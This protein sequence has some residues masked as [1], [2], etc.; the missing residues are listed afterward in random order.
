MEEE[1]E[2]EEDEKEE[3]RMSPSY[4]HTPDLLEN[5]STTLGEGDRRGKNRDLE[6]EEEEV[7]EEVN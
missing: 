7:E 6:K 3:R 1:E 5:S 4:T 2:K